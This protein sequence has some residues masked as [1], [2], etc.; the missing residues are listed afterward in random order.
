MAVTSLEVARTLTSDLIAEFGERVRSVLLFGSVARGEA[1]EGVSNVNVLV[2]LDDFDASTLRA[3]VPLAGRWSA[4]RAI[5]LLM[6]W[7]DWKR[8]TDVFAIELADMHDAHQL[9]H[10][11]DPIV[12]HAVDMRALRLQAEREL[13]GKIL[14]L[15]MGLLSSAADPASIGQVLVGALPSLATYLRAALRLSGLAV[16]ARMQDVLE[17]GAQLVGADAA[18]LLAAH[19][20]RRTNKPLRM[21]LD[22][23]RVEKYHSAA[24]RTVAFVDSI[25]G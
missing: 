9:L 8:A 17:S 13:R 18:G 24:E 16:P 14:Q 10:G 22:D 12:S 15:R 21:K 7:R 20:A 5:P 3:A 1:V 11:D 2:L 23:P 19:E 6:E 25:Q 4:Q